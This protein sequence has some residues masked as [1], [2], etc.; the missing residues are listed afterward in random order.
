MSSSPFWREVANARQSGEI[1][2]CLRGMDASAATA[3]RDLSGAGVLESVM[4][5]IESLN[6]LKQPRVASK[7]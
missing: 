5:K 2:S 1:I 4:S 7:T 3:P 6:T